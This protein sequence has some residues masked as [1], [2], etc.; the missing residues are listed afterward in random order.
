M[1]DDQDDG[2]MSGL[3]IGMIVGGVVVLGLLG[4]LVIFFLFRLAG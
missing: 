4:L 1:N 3:M 2:G